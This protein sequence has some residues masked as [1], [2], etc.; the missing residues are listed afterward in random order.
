[1]SRSR[2]K[3]LLTALLMMFFVAAFMPVMQRSTTILASAPQSCEGT[4]RVTIPG[5]VN[6]VNRC[7]GE[8]LAA[9]G[10][11]SIVFH[12]N[13][14]GDGGTHSNIH[15]KLKG[16]VTGNQG[17]EYILNLVANGQFDAP[18]GTDGQRQYYDLPFH[19]E[20]ISEGSAPNLEF[21]GTVRVFVLNCEPVTATIISITNFECHG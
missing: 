5:A 16:E 20:V 11:V 1:M 2:V 18:S 19:A 7:N 6:I 3:R 21:E 15:L 9:T 14:R 8:A 4:S 10:P 17:N 13:E 12:S